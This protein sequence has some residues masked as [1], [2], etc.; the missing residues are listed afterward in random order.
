[1]LPVN[2]IYCCMTQTPNR[3]SCVTLISTKRHSR[4]ATTFSSSRASKPD[5][6]SGTNHSCP[7]VPSSW[8]S[9]AFGFGVAV[10]RAKA[11]LIRSIGSSLGK[12]LLVLPLLAISVDCVGR[13]TG[14]QDTLGKCSRPLLRKGLRLSF[15]RGLEVGCWIC[16][17]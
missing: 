9:F 17:G 10:G 8:L 7:N 15:C 1:M 13:R 3:T 14:E 4:G 6:R 11:T 12:H 2:V 5:I 16:A